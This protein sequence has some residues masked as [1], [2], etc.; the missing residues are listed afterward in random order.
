MNYPAA[1]PDLFP[2]GPLECLAAVVDGKV[3]AA[4]N[5]RVVTVVG[6][7]GGL[8]GV[9]ERAAE[10]VDAVALEVEPNVGV[11]GRGDPDV[12]AAEEFLDDGEVGRHPVPGGE[13][14]L[15]CGG[16]GIGS[17]GVTQGG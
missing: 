3:S 9:A 4:P 1:S 10:D 6:L 13:S 2:V 14:R 7:G 16:R 12:S 17:D 11:H 8:G 15:S 5:R